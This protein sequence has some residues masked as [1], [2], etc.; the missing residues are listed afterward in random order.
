M[1]PYRKLK[2]QDS[3]SKLLLKEVIGLTTKNAN[4]LASNISGPNCIFMAGCVV[5]VY[6]VESGTQSHLIVSNRTPKPLSCIAIS[7][8][9]NFVAAGESGH[10]P[11]LLVWDCNNMAFLSELKSHRY[12]VSCTAFSPDGKHLV[13]VGLP[14]DGF[15]YLWDWRSGT[16][17]TKVKACSSCS[18]VESVGFSSDAK[19]IVT[20]G[21]K[22]LKFWKVGSSIKPRG[23]GGAKS[24]TMHGKLINLG[25]QKGCSFVAVTSPMLTK[26]S[27]VNCHRGGETLPIYALTDTGELT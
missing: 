13:S 25:H 1:R 12:G 17:V 14:H 4:G 22:H 27:L 7:N 24:L 18:P 10:Q 20:A 9:G 2:K 11:A 23:N 6:N 15:I 16:L 21:K 3:S 8:D 26:R 5:V 19:F